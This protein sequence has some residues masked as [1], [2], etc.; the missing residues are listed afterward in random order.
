MEF[1]ALMQLESIG[2]QVGRDRPRLREVAFHFREFYEIEAQQ[3]IVERRR[4]MQ[5]RIGIAAVTVVVRRLCA[6]RELQR[7]SALGL[8][9]FGYRGASDGEC[10]CAE[11]S[12]DRRLHGGYSLASKYVA[13]RFLA[14]T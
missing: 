11:Q 13:S 5:R 2:H 14:S 8:L 1:H 7:A 10:E 9:G 3:R 4:E 12:E 6:D